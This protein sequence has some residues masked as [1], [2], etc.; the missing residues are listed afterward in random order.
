MRCLSYGKGVRL[1]LTPCYSI[2]LAQAKI[3]KPSPSGPRMT[4]TRI[5]EGFLQIWN[6]SPRPKALIEKGGVR[7]IGDFQPISRRIL[8]TVR[9][10]AEIN[11]DQ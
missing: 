8:E 10:R 9:D 2:K 7:N 11:N 4:A 6:G 3:T 1:S 5:C